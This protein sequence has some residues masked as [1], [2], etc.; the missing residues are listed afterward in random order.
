M[1]LCQENKDPWLP[2]GTCPCVLLLSF[3]ALRLC[4][5]QTTLAHASRSALGL[6]LYL[7]IYFSA[8]AF[9]L[10]RTRRCPNPPC[11]PSHSLSLSH[12]LCLCASRGSS[13][14]DIF[15]A[16]HHLWAPPPF[17]STPAPPTTGFFSFCKSYFS[18]PFISK[19][20][21]T[22]RSRGFE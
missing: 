11:H 8:S 19:G 5:P 14:R 10:P 9:P 18:P 13:L 20:W 15:S 4:L 12:I 7:N 16:K 21:I 22:Q 6:S 17:Y 3:V 1:F 2:E